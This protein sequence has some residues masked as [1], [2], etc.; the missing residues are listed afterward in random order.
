MN[1]DNNDIDSDGVYLEETKKVNKELA[2]EILISNIDIIIISL[3]NFWN[4][5]NKE[6]KQI[7]STNASH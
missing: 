5:H 4:N 2:A 7:L 6:L 1:I 3:N